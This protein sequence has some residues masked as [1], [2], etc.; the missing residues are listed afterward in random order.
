M[1][2]RKRRQP[3]DFGMSG[4]ADRA[5]ATQAIEADLDLNEPLVAPLIEAEPSAPLQPPPFRSEVAASAPRTPARRPEPPAAAPVAEATF[6][7]PS[8]WPIYLIALAVSVLWATAPIAFAIG[9]RNSVA[10]LQNDAFALFVFGLLAVGP[11]AFVFGCAY[12]IRQGQKLAAET[13]RAK[14]MAED[15]LSPALSAAVRAGHVVQGVREEIVRAGA[16]ADDARET[17]LALRQA[18]SVETETLVENTQA[19]VRSAQ[20]LTGALG[21]ERTGMRDLAETLDAQATR[22]SDTITQQARMVTEASELADTQ[23]REAEATL[24]A[25]AA[26]LAAA[27][28]EAGD[29][30]RTAGEDLVRHIARLE[31]A[32]VG[33]S[34]QVRSVESGLS[35]QRAALITL[36]HALRADHDTFA[37]EAEAHAARLGEFITQARLSAVEMSDRAAKGGEA[38]KALMADAADQFRDLAETARAEREEFGQSSLQS[39]EAVSQAA[40]DQRA[41]LEAQT[42]AAIEA[43]GRAAEE[44]REAAARHAVTAREQVDQLSEAAF[45]AGQKANQVFE[46]RL[47][48]ARALVE[49]SSQMV[50]QAGA[51]TARK[52]DEGAA[53]ARETLHELEAML[54]ELEARAKSLPATARGQ[55]E[56]VRAAVTQGMEDLM[57]AARR[58]AEEAEAI[59]VAFQGRVR[60][61]FEMLSEAVRLMGTAAAAAPPIAAP[62]PAA[63]PRAVKPTFRAAYAAP[64]LQPPTAAYA[65]PPDAAAAASEAEEPEPAGSLASASGAVEPDV[66]PDLELDDMVEPAPD[67]PT[68]AKAAA[69]PLAERLG[70]RPRLKL[71]P[72]ASDEEF[73]SIFEAAGGPPPA[74]AASDD[75]DEAEEAEPADSWTW[76]D[77]LASLDGGEG[78]KLEDILAGELGKM[79]VDPAKLLPKARIDEIA[80][81]VQTGDLDGARQVVKRLAPAATRRIVRR[82]FTDE[83]LRNQVATYVRRYQTL[84]D[85]A[86]VRD[87]EGFL[88]ANLLGGEAG[89]LYLLLDAAAGDT[90]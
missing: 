39:L 53:A 64:T 37:S 40:A 43:L 13:R 62:K 19:S 2:F 72:T 23:L 46:A 31:T 27:A 12:M 7:A 29:A 36:S 56:Q 54:G 18:L 71:T 55:T 9:Y 48:E 49:Q 47:A 44:T 84:V 63:P 65:A 70:L 10:P 59:D 6:E 45:A 50:E 17:L 83:A 68:V 24:A 30:A 61:N 66:E 14:A 25:R 89:R 60:H 15:M 52:L 69:A 33:V 76:K 87:P 42:R 11:A 3:T 21:R 79:G 74:Q 67:H 58:T 80:A 5:V 77:L 1:N 35:D 20:E 81:A 51:A 41:Q 82:L 32:G 8:A 90:I 4:D 38:L 86:V 57:A 78:E 22:V 26:D 73:S 88:M 75:E 34:E 85:D 16:A 28:G